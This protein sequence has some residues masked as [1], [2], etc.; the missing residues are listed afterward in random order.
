MCVI[1]SVWLWIGVISPASVQIIEAFNAARRYMQKETKTYVSP[2]LDLG[3]IVFLCPCPFDYS[4]QFVTTQHRHSQAPSRMYP[5]SRTSSYS[6][7]LHSSSLAYFNRLTVSHIQ[8]YL[9][10]LHHSESTPRSMQQLMKAAAI[11]SLVVV[12]GFKPELGSP[13]QGRNTGLSRVGWSSIKT[14]ATARFCSHS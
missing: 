5:S 9:H 12:L 4:R 1:L 2:K 3:I 11:L 14:L 6:K 8:Q 10:S 13:N 7:P